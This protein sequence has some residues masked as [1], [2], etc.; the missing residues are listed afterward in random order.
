MR[1]TET[2]QGMQQVKLE[3]MGRKREW[4]SYQNP[5]ELQ[6]SKTE[7]DS[8]TV[9]PDPTVTTDQYPGFCSNG[10]CN[11]ENITAWKTEFPTYFLRKM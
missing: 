11:M 9:G 7:R 1:N 8:Q 6:D 5:G 3:A 10:V 2:S 4:A